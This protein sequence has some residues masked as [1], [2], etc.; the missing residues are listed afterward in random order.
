MSKISL[1]R[2]VFGFERQKLYFKI[3]CHMSKFTFKRQ[4]KFNCQNLN[5]KTEMSKLLK[6]DI[7]RQ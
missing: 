6:I 7:E 2:Q 3:G 1:K 4:K 5:V